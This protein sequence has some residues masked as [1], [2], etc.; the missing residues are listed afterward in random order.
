MKDSSVIVTR[1][2]RRRRTRKNAGAQFLVVF[3][4]AATAAITWQYARQKPVS[5]MAYSSVE[6]NQIKSSETD[7]ASPTYASFVR[8]RPGR[9]AYLYSVIPGGIASPEELRQAMDHDPVV[10]QQFAGFDFQRAHLIQVSDSQPMHVAYRMGDK[11]YWTRKKMALHKGETLI[12]DGKIA[13]RTRCGNRIALVP[14]GP[15]AFAEPT[16]ADLD[17]P[18]FSNDMVTHE[19]DPQPETYAD[20][21]PMARR[22]SCGAE[23]PCQPDGKRKPDSFLFFHCC[24]AVSAWWL[25]RRWWLAAVVLLSSPRLRLRLRP[26]LAPCCCFPADCWECCGRLRKSGRKQ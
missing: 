2:R 19:V 12:S 5:S 1:R 10:A 16:L 22:P 26:N 18:L 3:L 7:P 4:F 8:S 6:A 21:I 13:A 14:L 25:A 24:L 17:Q 20:A 11:V 9:P 15:P 23:I